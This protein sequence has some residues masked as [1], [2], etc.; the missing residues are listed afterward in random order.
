MRSMRLQPAGTCYPR[1][2]NDLGKP[3]PV[4]V[5]CFWGL[6]VLCCGGFLL[7]KRWDDL[8]LL[9]YSGF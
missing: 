7:Y 5:F 8:N 9:Q 4:I 3:G 6:I 2:G 1:V